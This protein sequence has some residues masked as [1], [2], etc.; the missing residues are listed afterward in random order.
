MSLRRTCPF[1][2]LLDSD[3]LRVEWEGQPRLVRLMDVDPERA[4]PGGAKPATEFG[5][6]ALRW[7]QDVYFKD[8]GEVLLEF[9]SDEISLSNSGK[10]LCYVFVRDDSCNVR[11]IRE[12]WSPCFQKYGNPRIHRQEMEQA[13]F[14]ARLEGRGI[15]GGLGGRG[16]YRTLKDYWQLR[17]GQIAS[18]RLATAMGEDILNCRMDYPDILA[19]ARARRQA[20]V[21]VELT[22]AFHNADGSITCQLGNPMQPFS[23]LF[24]PTMS[25]LAGFLEREYLGFGRP[26]YIYLNGTLTLSDGQPR[27]VIEHTDQ[28]CTSP[29]QTLR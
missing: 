14:W 23:A 6:R 19:I 22:R 20:N 2:G 1:L 15:W 8:V 27:I 26:N 24:P 3:T 25:G 5:R 21:F 17:A 9:I 29:P 11:L 16:D 28:V 10:L 4:T 13:E 12:G 7:A 18:Y